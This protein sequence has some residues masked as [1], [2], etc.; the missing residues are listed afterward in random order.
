MRKHRIV[1]NLLLMF[2]IIMML[3]P[4]MLK[5][6]KPIIVGNGFLP[7]FA[8]WIFGWSLAIVVLLI[9]LFLLDKR[10]EKKYNC[11]IK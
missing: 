8:A 9:T 6:T 2:C 5:A 10:Y 11:E 7:M 1:I 4:I 3:P